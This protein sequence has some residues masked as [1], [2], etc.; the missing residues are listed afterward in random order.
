MRQLLE[1]GAHFG[2]RTRYWNPQ[3]RPYIFGARNKIHIIN[4]EQTLPLLREACNAVGRVAADGGKVLF[5]GTKRAAQDIVAEEAERCDMPYVN[6]R[7]LGGMLTNFK[8]VKG[9]IKRMQELRERLDETQTKFQINKKERLS[10]TR[11]YEKLVSSLGGI[12]QMTS[13][14]DALFVIDVGYEN[15]AI[16]EARKLGIPVIGIVDTNNSPEGVDIV[17]PGNDDAIRAISVYA[18]AV[19]DA[20]LDA[21]GSKTEAPRDVEEADAA[22]STDAPA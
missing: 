7:W 21:H 16:R 19:A 20:V 5:V 13:L 8:T 10:L 11:E 14:P 2:H 15:I 17:V 1:A 9:S 12:E 6:R 3:M 18:Q 4:L 22:E